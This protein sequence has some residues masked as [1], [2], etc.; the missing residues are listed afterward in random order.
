MF[1]HKTAIKCWLSAKCCKYLKVANINE[2]AIVFAW[3]PKVK[4]VICDY[5][6]KCLI[7]QDF[8][9]WSLNIMSLNK[10]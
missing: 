8:K 10:K 4:W 5:N 6:H 2:E 7:K 1:S 3:V 9:M